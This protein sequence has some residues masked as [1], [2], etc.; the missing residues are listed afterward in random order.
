ML[1]T[2]GDMIGPLDVLVAGAA[3]SAGVTLV[4]HNVAEFS[5]VDGGGLVVMRLALRLKYSENNLSG[6][7]NHQ[8]L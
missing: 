4:T 7:N 6:Y 2:T 1:C 8:Q 5:R 3:L